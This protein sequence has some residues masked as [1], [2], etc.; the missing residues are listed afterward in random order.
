MFGKPENLST[1][2]CF[3]KV[4]L[5]YKAY[6]KCSLHKWFL[7]LFVLRVYISKQGKIWNSKQMKQW[8]KVTPDRLI[9]PHINRWRIN[10]FLLIS[11]TDEYPPRIKETFRMKG[12]LIFNDPVYRKAI[13]VTLAFVSTFAFFLTFS[14]LQFL[15]NETGND[16]IGSSTFL[17]NTHKLPNVS[18]NCVLCQI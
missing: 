5:N 9:T 14:C 13:R 3:G 8:E 18:A 2:W 10:G 6:Q 1:C 15:F 4:E 7:F 12:G 16:C 17:Q 11:C